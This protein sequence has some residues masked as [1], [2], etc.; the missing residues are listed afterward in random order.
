MLLESENYYVTI[1]YDGVQK[2]NKPYVF[3]EAKR[4]SGYVV[5]AAE[6]RIGFHGVPYRKF[7]VRR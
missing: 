3:D 7:A 2:Y 5:F 6:V 1:G 4:C